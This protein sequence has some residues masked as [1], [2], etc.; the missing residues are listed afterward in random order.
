M[1]SLSQR[2][3][4]WKDIKIGNSNYTIGGTG[5]LITLLAIMA[6][7]TPD[8]VNQ[9][10]KEVGGYY[11]ALVVWA[12]IDEALPR[13]NFIKRAYSYSNDIVA[14]A[15]QDYG[16]CPV[17][18]DGTK[19]GGDKHWVLYIGNQQIIDP[20]YGD[21]RSTSEYPAVGY[22]VI[23]IKPQEPTSSDEQRAIEV[24][25]QAFQE[26]PQDDPLKQGN[27][28]GFIRALKDEHSILK[29]VK[30]NEQILKDEVSD[31]E[32]KVATLNETMASKSLEINNIRAELESEER[33]NLDLS[34]QLVEARKQRD[35]FQTETQTY[36]NKANTLQKAL[37]IANES[38]NV[39]KSDINALEL[40]IKEM[41][42]IKLSNVNTG[43]L[44]Q[45]LIHRLFKK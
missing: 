42:Q 31:L 2:D 22:A 43:L 29:E 15:V 33:D 30:K 27:L 37:D 32:T 24:L 40:T 34:T 17:E 26:L 13:L 4:R 3:N 6:D 18:V 16:A 19:I 8:I 9:K 44:I 45:E 20:W 41:K 39:C 1:V 35:Q 10:L 7:T 5:C 23:G 38:L 11:G 28:E 14:K 21:I 25:K 12:K 36:Q